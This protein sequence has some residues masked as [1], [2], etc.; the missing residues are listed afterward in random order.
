MRNPLTTFSSRGTA[1]LAIAAAAGW[2]TG[3]GELPTAPPA[4]QLIVNPACANPAPLLASEARK[5]PD[6]LVDDYLVRLRDNS[7][8]PAETARLASKYAFV[9]TETATLVPLFYARLHPRTVA[10]LRCESSV[11]SVVFVNNTLPAP[12]PP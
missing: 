9:P 12:P 2:L 11:Q 3:C 6:R 7:N 10:S 8:G 1:L 5:Y 4:E